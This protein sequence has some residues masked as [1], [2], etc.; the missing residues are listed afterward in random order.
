M[1]S[2]NPRLINDV[3]IHPPSKIQLRRPVRWVVST[4]GITP[5]GDSHV[6]ILKRAR[7]PFSG[8]IQNRERTPILG[9]QHRDSR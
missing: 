4:E 6:N 7:T 5:W 9:L 8:L 1:T 3:A 2:V